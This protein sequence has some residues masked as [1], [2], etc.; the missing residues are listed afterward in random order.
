FKNRE[1][2]VVGG[3]NTAVE[4]ALY[5]THFASK[6][7]LVHRRDALRAEKVLQTRLF[8]NPKVEVVW[9]SAVDEIT[10]S[11]GVPPAVRGVRLRNLL[12]GAIEER[13]TAGVFVAIGHEPAVALFRDQL[14]LKPSG[15]LWTAP[16]TTATSRPGVF[17]AGDVADDTYR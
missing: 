17:A 5:L 3:G 12:T 6:V 10:G 4:E 14:R 8:A 9:N 1:V 11:A 2:V 7:I 15:Y 16:G 13:T